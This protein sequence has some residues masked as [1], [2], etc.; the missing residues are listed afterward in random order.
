MPQT[1]T[2]DISTCNG[3]TT[4]DTGLAIYNAGGD[5]AASPGNCCP[6]CTAT[7]QLT[8][9]VAPLADANLQLVASDDGANSTCSQLL[10]LKLTA[11]TNYL[12]VVGQV[13]RGQVGWPLVD[14]GVR[15]ATHWATCL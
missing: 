2:Y 3:G 5:L 8:W 10:D 14:E 7:T 12:L 1:S 4:V 6:Q 9:R 15:R 11:N 13:G